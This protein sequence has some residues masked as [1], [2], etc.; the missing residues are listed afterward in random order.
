MGAWDID[1]A[2][3]MYN[4]RVY[5]CCIVPKARPAPLWVGLEGQTSAAARTF[6]QQDPCCLRSTPP[7]S[8][9]QS[10]KSQVEVVLCVVDDVQLAA[11]RVVE[12]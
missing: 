8:A 5:V 6:G 1:A 11:G 3:A 2:H 7:D 4:S 9:Q 12:S 10:S